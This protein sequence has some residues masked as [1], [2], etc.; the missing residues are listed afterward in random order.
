LLPRLVVAVLFLAVAVLVL[1]MAVLMLSMA[2]P[3]QA[4]AV[5]VVLQALQRDQAEAVLYPSVDQPPTQTQEG[6]RS[7]TR[8]EKHVHH[9]GYQSYQLGVV[10]WK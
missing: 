10:H 9:A 8:D 3:F 6:Q 7:Q 4:V 5:L 1:G 2:V